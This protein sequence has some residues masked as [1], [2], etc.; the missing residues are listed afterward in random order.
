MLP[1]MG[2]LLFLDDLRLVLPKGKRGKL[3]FV[4]VSFQ[5]RLKG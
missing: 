5:P 4:L 1:T 2:S 3:V